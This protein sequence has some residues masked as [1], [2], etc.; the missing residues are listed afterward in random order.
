M[1]R[2]SNGLM[3][4]QHPPTPPTPQSLSPPSSPPFFFLIFMLFIV[5]LGLFMDE[6]WVTNDSGTFWTQTIKQMSIFEQGR[7]CFPSLFCLQ[8]I[9]KWT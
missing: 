6:V 2:D 7:S 8:E 5:S 3:F 9:L 4:V 1:L